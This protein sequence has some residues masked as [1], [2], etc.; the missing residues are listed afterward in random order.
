[1]SAV[2]ALRT[3]LLGLAVAI[4]AGTAVYVLLAYI[5]MD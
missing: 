1:M 5:T 2:T 4:V 3:L